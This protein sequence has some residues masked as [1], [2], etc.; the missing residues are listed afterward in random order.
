MDAPPLQH[1]IDLDDDYGAYEPHVEH[2]PLNTLMRPAASE[3]EEVLARTKT[4]ATLIAHGLEATMDDEEELTA[5]QEFHKHLQSRPM[6]LSRLDKPGIVLKLAAL[7]SEY[8]HQVIQD[9]DQ[10]RRYT[11][12]RLIEESDPK[13]PASQRLNALKLLGQITEIGLF[14]ERTEITVKTQSLESLEAK[15]HEKLITLLPTEYKDITPHE[16]D[17]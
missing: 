8:D 9:A 15:L 12:N 7:L 6:A 14:T 10:L 5:Q 11:T 1:L 4:T 16:P 2:A 13:M 17:A 3:E